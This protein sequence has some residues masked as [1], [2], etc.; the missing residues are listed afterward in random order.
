VPKTSIAVF[1]ALI[2][3]FT[4]GIL[5]I[6]NPTCAAAL[7]TAADDEAFSEHIKASAESDFIHQVFEKEGQRLTGLSDAP[8]SPEVAKLSDSTVK[9]P[10]LGDTRVP[11]HLRLVERERV[12][13]FSGIQMIRAS[14]G[15]RCEE[16]I[17]D[18]R[19]FGDPV[20]RQQE[21][22]RIQCQRTRRD[23]YQ[24]G[25]HSEGLARERT[26]LEL[27]L[28]P[29]TQEDMLTRQRARNRSQDAE[30][31]ATFKSAEA[32]DSAIEQFV[33]FL[34]A[35]AQSIRVTN[36]GFVFGNEADAATFNDLQNMVVKLQ[37]QVNQSP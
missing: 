23:L 10:A 3:I 13:F 34:D 30:L 31:A 24:R 25:T 11:L 22:R 1:N 33:H 4:L 27:K 19:Q 20:K 9:H 18:A 26:I 36:S 15:G 16:P 21:L 37:K 28:P 14:L 32:L 29:Y 6:P 7:R 12:A 2:C 5:D 17:A 8:L 35:H